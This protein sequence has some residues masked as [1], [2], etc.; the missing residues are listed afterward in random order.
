MDVRSMF[1]SIFGSGKN[2]AAEQARLLN[3][4]SNFYAPW[5]GNAYDD[6]TVRDCIDTIAR[7][8]GKMR[9]RHIFRRNG[10]VQSTVDDRLNYL[11][12]VK[13]NYLMTASEFLEKVAAQYFTYNNAFVFPQRGKDGKLIAIWPL[14]FASLELKEYEGGLY[15]QFTFGSG[16][17][18][19]VPYTDVVHIRRYFNRDDVWGDENG[20]IMKEDLTA[21]RAVRTA[22]VNAVSNFG[23]LRGILKWKQTLR[24]DDERAAWQKF[25]D[26][27]ATN[28]NGS[29]IGSLDNKADFQQINT[30]IT[31]FDAKQ[32]E[33]VRGAI[34]RHF[35]LND[36]IVTG[37]YNENE[38]IAF[39][40]SVLEPVAVKLSEELTDKLFTERERGWG[41]EIVL[42]CS[43]LSYMSVASKIKVCAAL[44]P[45]G[46]ISINEVREM[47]GYSGVV[48][49]D[50]RQVS[51]NYVKAGDQ[52]KY[53]T[54]EATPAKGGEGSEND[55]GVSD[56]DNNAE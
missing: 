18:T 14:N 43:R 20:R 4:Y 19:T 41:H 6:A 24:P 27:Y 54:G 29:G 35:G 30:P 46:C 48:G 7:H 39:Y 37:E 8:F 17:Q 52:S 2:P 55:E 15:C 3:G 34:Y 13:P 31:T 1:K 11:L 32:M 40:E 10:A 9:P 49:G 5:D 26:T 36:K 23:A 38:Y 56:D 33:Y 50:E 28:Q 22:I 44:T 25:V 45:I 16:E 21:L 42:E 53:Q 47:F 12:G 51:L